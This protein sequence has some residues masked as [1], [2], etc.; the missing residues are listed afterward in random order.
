MPA[1]QA[2]VISEVVFDE[3]LDWDLATEH[4]YVITLAVLGVLYRGLRMA[5]ARWP[6]VGT[7]LGYKTRLT[8]TPVPEAPRG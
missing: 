5:E 4:R 1:A 6:W 8:Y 3:I 7:L 2:M